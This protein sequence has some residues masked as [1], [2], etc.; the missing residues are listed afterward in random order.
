MRPL[1]EEI[2]TL[3]G[4]FKIITEPEAVR[5]ELRDSNLFGRVH[6]YL[7]RIYLRAEAMSLYKQ[8]Q[9][10]V[11]ELLEIGRE[12]LSIELSED[13]VSRVEVLFTDFLVRNGIL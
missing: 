13:D 12:H 10:L 8:W 11:H 6:P 2:E 5:A 9:V 3:A 7:D 1:P 4:R